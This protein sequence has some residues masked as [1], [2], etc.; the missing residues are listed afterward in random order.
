MKVVITGCNGGLGL[1]LM[2]RC[3][4]LG[5]EVVGTV[6][7]RSA[8]DEVLRR[9][10]NHPRL[11]CLFW[12]ATSPQDVSSELM[13]QLKSCDVLFNNAGWEADLSITRDPAKDK[14]VFDVDHE[15]FMKAFLINMHAPRHLMSVVV[16]QMKERGF[17]R[18]VNVAS[19]LGRMSDRVGEVNCPSYRLSKHA[20]VAL[21][22]EAAHQ[23]QGTDVLV[24]AVCPGWCQTRMGGALA[25]LPV[26][27]GVD[28]LMDVAFNVS[29]GGNF[30]VDGIPSLI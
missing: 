14:T 7:S 2:E 27:V 15:V 18:V 3:L 11:S 12:D 29:S 4:Q 9:A 24:N 22:L 17:G 16:P 26:S 21:T 30:F 19:A 10:P 8:A 28:R 20:L 23:L 6:R 1:G 5:H 25:P 13:Q